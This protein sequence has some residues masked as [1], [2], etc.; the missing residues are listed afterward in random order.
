MYSLNSSELTAFAD[1]EE[2][3]LQ[4]GIQ[5]LVVS[6]E[7]IFEKNDIDEL[8][9]LAYVVLEKSTNKYS[10]MNCCLRSIKLIANWQVTQIVQ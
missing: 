1:E 8:E 9:K 7:Y 3:L 6:F 5:Y 2:I 10:Q 4:D